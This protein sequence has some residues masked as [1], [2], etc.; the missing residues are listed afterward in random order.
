MS[1]RV[2]PWVS[3]GCWARHGNSCVDAVEG[4]CMADSSVGL[5][6]FPGIEVG[7]GVVVLLQVVV[8][9]VGGFGVSVPWCCKGRWW[10][11]SL[12][13]SFQ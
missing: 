4:G 6:V 13:T 8:P 11:G 7:M 9:V 2:A 3:L 12:T 5:V 1:G 10:D